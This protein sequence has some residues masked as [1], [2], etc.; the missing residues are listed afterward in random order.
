MKRKGIIEIVSLALLCCSGLANRLLGLPSFVVIGLG[1]VLAM[2][3]L[4]YFGQ[5]YSDEQNFLMELATRWVMSVG[6][7]G[8]ALCFV[9]KDAAE[10]VLLTGWLLA[11]LIVIL[12]YNFG[13]I[14]RSTVIRMWVVYG[15]FLAP[16]YMLQ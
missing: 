16:T 3:Y 4:L 9:V 7:V 8:F 1:G 2:L 6:S 5:Y 11:L 13:S 15:V 14:G 12:R 10:V